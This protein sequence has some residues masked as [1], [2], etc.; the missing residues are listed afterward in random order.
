MSSLVFGVRAIR[1]PR[2]FGDTLSIRTVVFSSSL[3]DYILSL[4]PTSFLDMLTTM[5]LI[6][7]IALSLL[8]VPSPIVAFVPRPTNQMIMIRTTTVRLFSTRARAPS[9]SRVSD[10]LLQMFN[11]QITNELEAS[12]LYLAASI[13]CDKDDLVGMAAYMRNEATEERG[14][15]LA[16]I[17][18]ANK[19]NMA[20]K[21]ED[22]KAPEANWK[23]VEEI[24]Q[25]VVASEQE[26]TEA[27]LA[28]GDVSASCKDHALTTFLQPYHIEQVNS[29]DSLSTILSKVTDE[30]RT[31]GLIRQL[32][33]ELGQEA[34]SHV[35]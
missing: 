14:H 34:G 22:V 7:F 2:S 23:N 35:V 12:Q 27:L 26:N 30:N 16:F 15:A 5:V 17:D 9:V 31:P 18:F 19:R 4:H 32:D 1:E 3:R 11:S 28:L 29:E 10:E 24:W 6:S 8:S 33:Y 13:W 20:I 25:N 21:L